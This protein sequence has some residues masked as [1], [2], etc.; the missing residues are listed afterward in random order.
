MAAALDG[1]I[2]D[3]ELEGSDPSLDAIGLV[4]A[5]PT[6]GQKAPLITLEAA[7]AKLPPEVLKA[8]EEKFMGSLTQVRHRDERDQML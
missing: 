3:A 5:L 4:D 7:Q 1:Q 2:S 6:R 8:L